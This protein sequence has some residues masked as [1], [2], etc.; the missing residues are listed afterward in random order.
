TLVEARASPWLPIDLPARSD[1][2][3]QHRVRLAGDQFE[4][5]REST[6][7]KDPRC[8]AVGLGGFF[9]CEADDVVS[10]VAF[11]EAVA[12]GILKDLQ[13][14]RPGAAGPATQSQ[15]HTT[16]PEPAVLEA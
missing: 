10:R 14:D 13:F 8:I 4:D 5:L 7:G 9:M 12:L 11:S 15:A 3:P 2:R 1:A 16:A 6:G